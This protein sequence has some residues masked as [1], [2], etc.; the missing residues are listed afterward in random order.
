MKTLHEDKLGISG[1]KIKTKKDAFQILGFDWAKIV[2]VC[3]GWIFFES[4]QEY[5]TWK[6]QN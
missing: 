6:N 2:K 4:M 3:G 5:K 1:Y